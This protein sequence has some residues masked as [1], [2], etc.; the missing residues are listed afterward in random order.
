MLSA[1]ATESGPSEITP[2]IDEIPRD[3]NKQEVE[4]TARSLYST[5]CWSNG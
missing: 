1:S 3:Q 2:E 4:V 5:T